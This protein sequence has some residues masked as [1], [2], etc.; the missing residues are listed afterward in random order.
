MLHHTVSSVV[1]YAVPISDVHSLYNIMGYVIHNTNI[2][3][4]YSILNSHHWRIRIEQTQEKNHGRVGKMRHA[5]EIFIVGK[6]GESGYVC[7]LGGCG[8]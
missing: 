6:K 5:W 2:M 3:H 4:A 1:Y 7:E 8:L